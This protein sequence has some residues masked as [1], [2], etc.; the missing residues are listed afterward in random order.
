[1]KFESKLRG[2]LNHYYFF[3]LSENNDSY[4]S[5]SRSP[6][7]PILTNENLQPYEPCNNMDMYQLM[8]PTIT[9]QNEAVK[10]ETEKK[11]VKTGAQKRLANSRSGST[12]KAKVTVDLEEVRLHNL[13]IKKEAFKHVR[14]PGKSKYSIFLY[15]FSKQLHVIRHSFLKLKMVQEFDIVKI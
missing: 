5:R 9:H 12:D 8:P 7:P 14:K 1:M 15:S 2:F 6:S 11:E 4:G 10:P 3:F 13:K